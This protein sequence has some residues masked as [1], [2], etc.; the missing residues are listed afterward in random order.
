VL[1]GFESGQQPGRIVRHNPAGGCFGEKLGHRLSVGQD[2][3]RVEGEAE[4]NGG[5][6]RL[7][8]G[9]RSKDEPSDFEQR[10]IRV[11]VVEDHAAFRQAFA[12]LLGGEPDIEVAAR[13]GSLAETREPI[14][15][16]LDVAV[17][18][19]RGLSHGDGG[20]LIGE[21]RRASP[22][23]AV[24][25][26]SAAVGPGC[27]EGLRKAGADAVLARGGGAPIIAEVVR[28]LAGV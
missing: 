18:D 22:G 4:H 1:P 24:L 25:V 9:G 28:S 2:P 12:F 27:F 15:A 19:R 13:A 17:V 3:F 23:A 16:A 7:G 26:L 6:G 5:A 11:L 14:D 8:E 21:L 20:E 10:T